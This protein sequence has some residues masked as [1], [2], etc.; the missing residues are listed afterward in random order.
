MN[1]QSIVFRSVSECYIFFFPSMSYLLF[2]YSSSPF[3][4]NCFSPLSFLQYGSDQLTP[5]VLRTAIGDSYY[6]SPL[7]RSSACLPYL[8]KKKCIV[9]TRQVNYQC[10]IKPLESQC[11]KAVN[12]ASVRKFSESRARGHLTGDAGRLSANLYTALNFCPLITIILF[13]STTQ[14]SPLNIESGIPCTTCLVLSVNC[15]IV[16]LSFLPISISYFKCHLS[17]AKPETASTKMVKSIQSNTCRYRV[18]SP[19][20]PHAIIMR[21]PVL[22]SLRSTPPHIRYSSF[23]DAVVNVIVVNTHL[24]IFDLMTLCL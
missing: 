14:T 23:T 9:K 2:I 19:R 22:E 8:S 11:R 1:L 10:I 13:I 20:L 12:Q 18:M 16:L 17:A 6:H 7:G 3:H 15:R 24:T 4:P 21:R 5:C